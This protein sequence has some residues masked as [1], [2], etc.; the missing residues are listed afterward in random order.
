MT[1]S[2]IVGVT[3]ASASRRAVDW[4]ARHAAQTGAPLVL[5]AVVEDPDDAEAAQAAQRNLDAA[6]ARIAQSVGASAAEPAASSATDRSP[7][8]S[9]PS[10]AQLGEHPTVPHPPAEA[11]QA[12]ATE[13][14]PQSAVQARVAH[15][16]PTD[17]LTRASEDAAL[18]VIGSDHPADGRRGERGR[19]IVADA[20]CTVVVVPDI[21]TTGRHGIVVG[22]D[23][24][25]VTDAAVQFAA[26]QAER[27]GDPVIG[28]GVWAPM[29]ITSDMGMTGDV[30]PVGYPVDLKEP[31]RALVDGVL[32][33]VRA[34]H[35]D[36]KIST[37]VEE[38]EPAWV[39]SDLARD[40][41]LVVVGTH[42]R[43][44]LARFFLGSVSDQVLTDLATVT[45]VVR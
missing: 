17:E 41:A 14:A 18:L 26:G 32:D 45:A 34:A 8:P 38:G 25:E 40:A 7:Q 19:K 20:H 11:A 10:A 6:R 30:F 27:S 21:D 22:I 5:L 1:D 16:S 36:L 3:D 9:A 12:G 4:A 42:G 35:P 31:T 44:R 2:I 24:S 29:P 13:S 28:V 15:G 33:P 37:R 43:G 39:L 23:G